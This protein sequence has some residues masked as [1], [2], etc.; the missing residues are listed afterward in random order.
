[1]KLK[2]AETKVGENGQI[3]YALYSGWVRGRLFTCKKCGDTGICDA[4]KTGAG[5]YCSKPCSAKAQRDP[6]SIDKNGKGQTTY[7]GICA[8]PSCQ[9]AFSAQRKDQKCCSRRCASEI[10]KKQVPCDQCG[11]II[12]GERTKRGEFGHV[13]CGTE[14]ASL[15][16][17]VE[18]RGALT[19][20]RKS[21]IAAAFRLLPNQ[22][23]GCMIDHR[24]LLHVHHKDGDSGNNPL[25]CSNWEIV[26]GN[27]HMIR[28]LAW[29][30]RSWIYRT[31]SLTPRELLP[32]FLPDGLVLQI[33]SQI[34]HLLS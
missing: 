26:C 32:L 27:C 15:A 34:P 18:N 3:Y 12:E 1:M 7:P 22:C 28:H 24:F 33:S 25:D 14:C 17:L 11:K 8:N 29:N 16:T 10:N 30:G 20:S 5:I 19:I 2:E 13:Y 23:V 9:K 31:N 4:S 6:A 21:V